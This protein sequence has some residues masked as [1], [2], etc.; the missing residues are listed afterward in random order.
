MELT[1]RIMMDGEL[2]SDPDDVV[3]WTPATIPSSA[4]VTSEDWVFW[5]SSDL[6]T[7]AEPVN[8]SLVAVPKATTIVSSIISVSGGRRTSWTAF[9]ATCTSTSLYPT[10]ENI[11]TPSD[12]TVME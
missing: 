8:D 10:D 7:V 4:R 1:P 2:P 12:G 6:T 3:I 11:S 9:D 5:R